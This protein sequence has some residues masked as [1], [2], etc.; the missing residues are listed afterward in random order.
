M[1]HRSERTSRG[2]F[3]GQPAAGG[4]ALAGSLGFAGR[5]ARGGERADLRFG[6]PVGTLEID[7]IRVF[8]EE[9][10]A[11]KSIEEWTFA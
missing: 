11:S 2:E 4:A 7:W 1:R 5:G 8:R 10:G 6:K 3:L 9:G